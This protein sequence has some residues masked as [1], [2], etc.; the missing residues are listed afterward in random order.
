MFWYNDLEKKFFFLDWF[1]NCKFMGFYE[2]FDVLYNLCDF[3]ENGENICYWY[4]LFIGQ[5]RIVISEND[6]YIEIFLKFGRLRL[7]YFKEEFFIIL[8]RLR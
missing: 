1:R 6:E 2:I 3:G 8:C 5:D 4:L 7:L